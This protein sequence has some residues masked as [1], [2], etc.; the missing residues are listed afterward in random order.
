MLVMIHC[1]GYTHPKPDDMTDTEHV[2]FH[3]EQVIKRETLEEQNEAIHQL[4]DTVNKLIDR[5]ED[6]RE[7]H[8]AT[9][10]RLTKIEREREQEEVTCNDFIAL[11]VVIGGIVFTALIIKRGLKSRRQIKPQ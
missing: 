1:R 4:V 7:K 8:K 3:H 9:S 2:E 10:N 5:V 11:L 6:L